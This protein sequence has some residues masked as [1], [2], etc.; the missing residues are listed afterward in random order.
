MSTSKQKISI[1]A[2]KFKLSIQPKYKDKFENIIRNAN[3]FK[4]NIFNF[5]K[6][7]YIL[8][9]DKYEL[10]QNDFQTIFNLLKNPQQKIKNKSFYDFYHNVFK[11]YVF[12]PSD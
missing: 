8:K 11:D 6:C 4:Y 2:V 9:N 1:K 7:Y 12:N 3:L 5:I 10:S